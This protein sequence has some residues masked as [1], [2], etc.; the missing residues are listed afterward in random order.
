M[1]IRFCSWQKLRNN[2]SAQT[3]N[4][5]KQLSSES[6]TVSNL[7]NNKQKPS[8][9]N[10]QLHKNNK[11][12]PA[13]QNGNRAS[14]YSL[15]KPTENIN[16]P[17]NYSFAQPFEPD[18]KYVYNSEYDHLNSTLKLTTGDSDY[19]TSTETKVTNNDKIG[20]YDHLDSLK[21]KEGLSDESISNYD[22]LPTNTGS[23]PTYDVSGR[24]I[25]D[26]GGKYDHLPSNIRSD[27]TSDYQSTSNGFTIDNNYNYD[28]FVGETMT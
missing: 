4:D 19:L 9:E 1:S 25:H 28:H 7:I 12:F 22:H 5:E 20:A 2:S 15:A 23:D 17:G 10:I 14:N 26:D 16:Q 24:M 18:D 6:S 27:P 11:S 8:I 13:C 3:T 21:R